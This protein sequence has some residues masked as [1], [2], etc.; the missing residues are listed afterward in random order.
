MG[1]KAEKGSSQAHSKL[2]RD[3]QLACSHGPVRLFINNVGEIHENGR[4]VIY[5]LCP[6]SSD[7]IGFRY[8]GQVSS[9]AYIGPC[10]QF[11]ALEVKTGRAQPTREQSDFLDLVVSMGGIGA[12][13]RSVEEARQMLNLL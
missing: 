13:V 2:V 8:R 1:W 4:H 6:G 12:V 5:G 9:S 11:V 3:I 10:A 7:L